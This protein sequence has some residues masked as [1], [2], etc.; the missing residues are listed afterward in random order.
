[1]TVSFLIV[2]LAATLILFIF[3]RLTAERIIRQHHQQKTD[4]FA[5]YPVRPGDIVFVGDSITDNGRWHELFPHLPVKNRGINGD[6]VAGVLQRLGDILAGQPAAVFLLIGTN[7][8]PWYMYH[9]DSYILDTYA[10]ILE[11]CK[12]ESPETQVFV[13][14]ILPRHRRYARRIQALNAHLE[15]LAGRYG[16][17]FINLFPHFAS[18]D[19][20]IRPEFSNDQLHLLAAGYAC[21]AEI[22]SP[23]LNRI[24]P[25]SETGAGGLAVR[26]ELQF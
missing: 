25:V 4:F 6:T 8:L 23:Y 16:F 21:W 20:Q 22:L 10:A 18:S 17:T 11:C 1:M 15:E 13:Q 26:S 5:H 14:S 19:G 2:M 3:T 12:T 9:R 24:H 7:D